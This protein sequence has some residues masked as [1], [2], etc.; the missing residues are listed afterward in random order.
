MG[1][2][3][4]TEIT[5]VRSEDLLDDSV[6]GRVAR[7][8][9]LSRRRQLS[10]LG[11]AVVALPLLTLLLD[12]LDE[13]LALDGQVLLYLLVVVVVA[14]IGGAV[15]ALISAVAAALLI[16]YFF[17][18]PIHTLTVGDPDQVVALFV[19]VAVAGLVSG[20]VEIAVQADPG[21][22]AGPGR[23]RDDVGPGGARP[24]RR[25]V[26]ARGAPARDEHL[27]DGVRRPQGARA[28]QQRV[29]GRRQGRLGAA[30]GRGAAPLRRRRRAAPAAGRPRPG[31]VRR[32]R[33]RARDLRRRRPD[34]LRG[35]SPERRGRGGPHSR[36]RGQAADG[37]AGGRRPRSADP[38]C[39]DQGER[40]LACARP[41]SS[42]RRRSAT[43]CSRRSR[44]RPIGST[45]SSATCSTPA[46]SR[47]A[48]SRSGPRPSPSTRSPRP[49]PSRFPKRP[50]SSSSTSRRTS[51]W[52]APIG[53]C[54]SGSSPTCSTTRSAMAAVRSRSRSGRRAGAENAK[55]EIVD[56]GPGVPESAREGLFEPFQR[57]GDQQRAS[58]S[59]SRSPAASSRRW[60]AR[61]SRTALPAAG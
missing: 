12:A 52:S 61:W 46:G 17:V 34:R 20:A 33:A 24:D 15:A 60:A 19:F 40:Q 14:L 11:F 9:G 21:G 6:P 44:T 47:P 29:G 32:G 50:G 3:V 28:G 53:D 22:R 48:R 30:R 43:S 8:L 5:Y 2:P 39:R 23:G 45:P 25:G 27:P 36:H 4:S 10:G 7:R 56:H 18:D 49:P 31:A 51:H 54:S 41:T 59:A 42:G 1:A 26:A 58:A 13:Q 38:T 16:N 57:A 55:V 37:A 35:A